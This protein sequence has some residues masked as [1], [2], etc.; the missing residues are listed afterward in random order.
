MEQ[1]QG[2]GGGIIW[3][4]HNT[5]PWLTTFEKNSGDAVEKK[6][7]YERGQSRVLGMI[8]CEKNFCNPREAVMVQDLP[9][10][11][12]VDTAPCCHAWGSEAGITSQDNL[13]GIAPRGQQI[14]AVI[15]A[16]PGVETGVP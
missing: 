14:T 13:P 2:E 7:R 3:Q 9:S 4:D 1:G 6:G 5:K 11:P 8:K 15:H 16:Q 12:R 10:T